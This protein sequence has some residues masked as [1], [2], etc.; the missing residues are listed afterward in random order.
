MRQPPNDAVAG[1]ALAATG[2]APVIRLGQSAGQH[3]MIGMQLLTRYHQTQVIQAA[4][5]RQISRAKGNV[6]HVE[7]FRWLA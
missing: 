5:R 4:E 6:T 7:V 1:P 3:G 2:T